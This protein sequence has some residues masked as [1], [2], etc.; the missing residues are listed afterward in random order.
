M[1]LA[2]PDSDR[3]D[4]I[5]NDSGD[6]DQCI[7]VV[8]GGD[9]C[10]QSSS[11]RE[12]FWGSHGCSIER[13]DRDLAFRYRDHLGSGI[14]HDIQDREGGGIGLQLRNGSTGGNLEA[15]GRV[16]FKEDDAIILGGGI[17]EIEISVAI[18]VM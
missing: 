6:I 18:E 3:C 12:F 13:P 17:D 8:V 15:A 10:L 7:P 9:E 14:A 1:L 5:G 2:K 11:R 4:I 16:L